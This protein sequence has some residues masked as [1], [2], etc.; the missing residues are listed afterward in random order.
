MKNIL[1]LGSEGFLGSV[2]VP[3]LLKEKN[4]FITGVDKCFF[5]RNNKISQLMGCIQKSSRSYQNEK[6]NDGGF[7]PKINKSNGTSN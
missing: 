1:I 3:Y 4:I 5:G 7:H 2:L 6:N